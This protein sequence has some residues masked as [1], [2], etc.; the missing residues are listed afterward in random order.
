MRHLA[1]HDK[2]KFIMIIS[3]LK[4]HILP[5]I[6]LSA[7][8]FVTFANALNNSF[9]WDDKIVIVG[10]DLIK[11]VRNIPIFFST[12]YW[13]QRHLAV[14][15]EYD[16][17][18]KVDYRPMVMTTFALD[19]SLWRFDPHGYHLTNLLLHLV[20]VLLIYALISMIGGRGRIWIG[21]AFL[22]SLFFATNPIHT[23]S[24]TWVKNRSDI[25]ALLFLL[26]S[27]F[28]FIGF[29][30]TKEAKRR[31]LLYSASLFFYIM[32]LFSKSMALPLPF[33]MAVYILCFWGGQKKV[34]D[35]T[36][37]L[38]FFGV[39][40]LYVLFKM[41]LLG[42]V[43]T[44]ESP[45]EPLGAYSHILLIFKTIGYY[46]KLLI[47]PVN[48]NADRALVIPKSFFEP[49][50]AG[51][52]GLLIALTIVAARLFFRALSGLGRKSNGLILFALFWIFITLLPVS[53]I[54]FLVS[55]PIA[56]QRLYIPSAGF[57]LLLAIGIEALYY[58]NKRYLPSAVSRKAAVALCVFITVLY[59]NTA[60]RRNA[61]WRDSITFWSKTV[62]N[63]V[64]SSRA[65][66]NLGKAYFSDG[67]YAEAA[68]A[69]RMAI[70]ISKKYARAYN[71]LGITYCYTGDI[72]NAINSLKKA[73][74]LK[75]DYA[76]AYNNLGWIYY[77]KL[78]NVK[79]AAK[80]FK[81]AIDAK[82]DYA[83]A[84][85]NIGLMKDLSGL[86]DKAVLFYKKAIDLNP[87]LGAGPYNNL[88]N[89]YI[90]RGKKMERAVKLLKKALSLYPDN[91]AVMDTF[92]SAMYKKGKTDEALKYFKKSAKLLPENAEIYDH[93]AEAYAK[94]DMLKEAKS[95]KERADALRRKR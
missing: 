53:N 25:L 61:D 11:S 35:L 19:H 87:G 37:T 18:E 88:A 71:N 32:A 89:I 4:R 60:I 38:P 48:L 52:F 79:K 9:I 82:P 64:V 67:R 8:T 49:A 83:E 63:R 85:Y 36:A 33:I 1:S 42:T 29:F 7:V 31:F 44:A 58:L 55:R 26:L 24:V 93:L 70:V 92:G 74:A 40:A 22:T 2:I 51:S 30:R 57:S 90:K 41:F 34:K 20:N 16:Q 12:W 50:V 47:L 75:P 14:S 91:P 95:A 94:K 68:E 28:S 10:N 15:E 80:F 27:M 73:V 17:E 43:G 76:E 78:H 84:F 23:E 3:G 21:T 81:K 69:Y 46:L 59:M 66:N 6:V 77:D 56:E 5:L 13:K 54:V 62:E 65:F 72:N 39:M 86:S 45:P